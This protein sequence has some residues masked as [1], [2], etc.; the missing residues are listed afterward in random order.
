MFLDGFLTIWS[1]NKFIIYNKSIK[2]N[3][4][5]FKI[6]IILSKLFNCQFVDLKK[7]MNLNLY[8]FFVFGLIFIILELIKLK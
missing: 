6:V 5:I 4:N 7:I 2:N 8:N 1:S 3:R